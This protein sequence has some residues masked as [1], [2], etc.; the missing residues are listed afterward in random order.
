MFP[1][2]SL[3][4][5]TIYLFTENVVFSTFYACRPQIDKP[6]GAGS[7]V[8]VLTASQRLQ[9]VKPEIKMN[10]FQ[11][12]KCCNAFVMLIWYALILDM[13]WFSD[14]TLHWWT[15]MQFRNVLD[16]C[17]VSILRILVSI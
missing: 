16:D 2:V 11:L 15:L 13:N 3:S 9:L 8:D 1:S 17:L 6:T 12:L 5:Y 10:W 7:S 14:V 4:L